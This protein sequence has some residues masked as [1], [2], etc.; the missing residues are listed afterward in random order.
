MSTALTGHLQYL[1]RTVTSQARSM[2]LTLRSAG[3]GGPAADLSASTVG[4]EAFGRAA[5]GDSF[6]GMAQ[7]GQFIRQYRAAMRD[8]QYTSIRPLATKVAEQSLKIARK[9]SA[10]TPPDRIITKAMAAGFSYIEKAI[11]SEG[12]EPLDNHWLEDLF[13][14]PNPY[15]TRWELLFCLA[16][17]MEACG[18]AILWVDVDEAGGRS[19]WYMP[20]H[21]VQPVSRGGDPYA[22][23]R[24]TIPGVQHNMPL[25]PG[26]DIIR[27]K[28]PSP[29]DPT[30]SLS[31][32]AAQS[33]AINTDDHIQDAQ[34]ASM[35]NAIRPT[36][37]IEVGEVMP[38]PGGGF[39]KPELTVDQ[40]KDIIEAIRLAYRGSIHNGDPIVLDALIAGIHQVFPN[41][42]ELDFPNGSMLTR[43]RIMEGYGTNPIVVGRI[44]GANRASAYVAHEG[45][46]EIKVNPLLS[47][48]GQTLTSWARR[49]ESR[50]GGK[51]YLW[52]TKAQA[53]DADLRLR[54]LQ[55]GLAANMIRPSEFRESL[56]LKPDPE[57]ERWWVERQKA[58]LQ[59]AQQAA[60]PEPSAGPVPPE[61]EP[62]PSAPA[63]KRRAPSAPKPKRATA[64]VS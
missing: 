31:P 6:A 30:A 9:K 11:E 34:L 27:F 56:G 53:R 4:S 18:E 54:E 55:V 37:A 38:V 3:G 17:S 39:M 25:V 26:A 36:V 60:L 59:A 35:K 21:W 51:L 24:L 46:Y 1:E 64:R 62:A 2:G 14:E 19:V 12:L 8:H 49:N 15:M 44:E 13:E 57:I 28:Y 32:T 58:T 48:I 50:L 20:R 23:W 7:S 63:K 29:A 42:A 40:R 43:D 22:F 61:P 16:F 47:L 10:T 45:F 52:F 41:A 5:T 33:R